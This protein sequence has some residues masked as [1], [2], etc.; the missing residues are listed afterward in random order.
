MKSKNLFAQLKRIIRKPRHFVVP[1][2]GVLVAVLLAACGKQ[3]DSSNSSSKKTLNLMQS[4]ELLSLDTVKQ[5]NLNEF[6]TL[7]NSMEGLYRSN[8]ENKLVPAMATSLVKP[9]N[10][11]KTYV[12]H[13]RKDAKWSNGDPVTAQ[14]FVNPWRR[15]VSPTSQSG[16][17]YIFRGI[18][19]ANAIIDGKK[20]PNPLGATAVNTHTLK[21]ELDYPMPYFNKMMLLPIFFP[22][23]TNTLNKFGNKYGSSSKNMYFN[24]AF[25]VNGWTGS[26]LSWNLDK[27][28]YYYNKK[29][30]KLNEIKMQV[31]KDANTAHQ[32]YQDGQLDDA[33]I[34]GTTAQGLQNNKNLYHF[35]RAGV[36]YLRLNLRK[37]HVFNNTKLRKAVSLAI[38]KDSLAKKVL[39][40]GS[41]RADTFVAPE[42]SIDPTTN[43]DFAKET[44]PTKKTDVKE[45]KKLWREGLK[46][47]GKKKVNI[48]YYTDDQ[49]INKNIAQFVQS[50]MEEKLPGSNVSIHA[51]PV[52]NS[53]SALQNGTFDMNFGFRFAD[54]GDPIGDLNVLK[55]D[56]VSNYGK[57]NSKAYDSYLNAAQTFAAASEESYWKNMR[58]AQKQLNQDMPVI[59]LYTMIESHLL[60]PKVRGIMWHHVGQVDYT[61]AYFK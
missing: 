24:G 31:V 25:Y 60:N 37:N 53:Q 39:S 56:N 50:Q 49:S 13:L 11:G 41:Q 22:Q 5:A 43:K 32:L 51:V 45:A 58:N 36:Y 48:D 42:L 40:D 26:N 9:T 38:D 27:N 55:S 30:I 35:H 3:S 21:V 19:N 23:S 8:K 12:Y 44:E 15:S 14:D 4:G 1:I 16:Y 61:R 57:Y 28:P 2:I 46:E 33:L 6:N 47:V 20:K 54:F 7:T 10:N 17:G 29:N 52:K 34:T 59:P 18:K